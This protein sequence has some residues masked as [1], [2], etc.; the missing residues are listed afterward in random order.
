MLEFVGSF[1]CFQ[2][3][4]SSKKQIEPGAF[5]STNRQK[6]CHFAKGE[7]LSRA[8]KISC[9]GVCDLEHFQG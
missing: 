2:K 7:A 9:Q 8:Y 1:S 4:V 3:S 5:Q 6:K